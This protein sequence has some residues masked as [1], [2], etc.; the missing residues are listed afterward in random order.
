MFLICGLNLILVQSLKITIQ[1]DDQQI[2]G[3]DK[4]PSIFL[5]Q[6]EVS[7]FMILQMFFT[8]HTVLKTGEHHSQTDIP[9]F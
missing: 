1:L 3:K 8:T 6:M 4:Y 5:Y 2:M 7:V 9:K